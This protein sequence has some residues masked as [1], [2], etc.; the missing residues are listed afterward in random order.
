MNIILEKTVEIV[1]SRLRSELDAITVERAVLGLFFTGVRLSTGHGGLCFTPVKEMPEA[2]CCPSSA[3]AMPL[4]GRLS[5]RPVSDYLEYVF[6]DN[7]L[8][9]AL[10][11]AALNALS[12]ILFEREGY[13]IR[14]ADAFDETEPADY[15]RITVVGALVPIIKK[16]ISAGSDFSIL[17]LDPKTLKEHEMKYFVPADKAGTVIPYSDLL[18]ITGVTILNDT[19]PQLLEMA[20]PG[21]EITVTGPTA[22]MIPDVLFDMGVTTAGGIL[23]TDADRLLDII[24]EGG[25]GYHF[26]GRYAERI[27][28][29][30]KAMSH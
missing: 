16:L 1:K 21:A 9:K 12:S 14:F 6:S 26:F 27:I 24:A 15:G 22:G 13:D 7:P 20:K 4:S 5:G 25:S 30:N 18:V 10:G 17:E 19:L 29:K 28:I 3:R 11:I 23:V 8:K 2:V